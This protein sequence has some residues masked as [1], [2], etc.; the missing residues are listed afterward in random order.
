VSLSVLVVYWRLWDAPVALIHTMLCV[1]VGGSL[2]EL[3]LC[4]F[5]GLP[6]SKAWRPERASLRKW[7]PAYL[8]FFWFVS[9]GLPEIEHLCLEERAGLTVLVA[10][11]ASA[12]FVLRYAHRRRRIMPGEDSAEPVH[13]Q[14]LNLD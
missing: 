4:G 11:V 3:L 12:G 10:T 8:L 13:V 1:A 9:R 2:I 6:C 14:V 5:D 7:W